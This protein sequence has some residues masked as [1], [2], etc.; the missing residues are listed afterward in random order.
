MRAL[1][2]GNQNAQ[3]GAL[4][5]LRKYGY[6]AWATGHGDDRIFK[7]RRIGETDWTFIEAKIRQSDDPGFTVTVV[8]R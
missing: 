2:E 8:K 1:A 7:V 6:E 4:L 3:Y 5:A